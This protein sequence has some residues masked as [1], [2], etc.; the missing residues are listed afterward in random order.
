ME[1]LRS[2]ASAATTAVWCACALQVLRLSGVTWKAKHMQQNRASATGRG[3]VQRHERVRL[4][5]RYENE[6]SVEV[7]EE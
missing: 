4:S 6:E 3:N 5:I 1:V 7:D 2:S